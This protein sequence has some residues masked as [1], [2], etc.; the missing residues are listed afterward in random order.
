MTCVLNIVRKSYPYPDLE[1][2]YEKD[3]IRADEKSESYMTGRMDLL[4]SLAEYEI[5]SLDVAAYMAGLSKEV[6]ENKIQE[7]RDVQKTE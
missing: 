6:F 3:K 4:Y 5:I 2:D 7:W 1:S